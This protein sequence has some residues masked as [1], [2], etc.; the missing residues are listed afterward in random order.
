MPF[1]PFRKVELNLYTEFVV[2]E[3][4]LTCRRG[5]EQAAPS[6]K[7]DLWPIRAGK[8]K[9]Q[10]RR[11]LLYNW[12]TTSKR[13]RAHTVGSV[14]EKRTSPWSLLVFAY[15]NRCAIKLS[16]N[17]LNNAA[18]GANLWHYWHW[19]QCVTAWRWKT[20]SSEIH[21]IKP[22][23]KSESTVFP[24][25]FISISSWTLAFSSLSNAICEALKETRWTCRLCLRWSV[26]GSAGSV[27]LQTLCWNRPYYWRFEKLF[28]QFMLYVK[29]TSRFHPPV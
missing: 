18:R 25:C 2:T 12:T 4:T 13:T 1:V 11:C 16:S 29:I 14:N 19:T 28:W 5:R 27:I 24:R 15:V 23:C 22:C 6:D 26:W 21:R 3:E 7:A 17:M 8:L 10:T 20:Q 9:E